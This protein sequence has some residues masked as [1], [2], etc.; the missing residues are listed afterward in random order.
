[1]RFRRFR[2][3]VVAL[4]MSFFA[5]AK[6]W[7]RLRSVDADRIHGKLRVREQILTSVDPACTYTETGVPK[8]WVPH[9]SREEVDN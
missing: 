4:L 7:L 2:L 3:W 9:T 8:D 6:E 5:Y 1:M